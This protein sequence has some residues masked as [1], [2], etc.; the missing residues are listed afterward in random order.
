MTQIH[1]LPNF[2]RCAVVSPDRLHRG[3]GPW[4]V[5]CDTPERGSGLSGPPQAAIHYELQT[6]EED[7]VGYRH[8][9]KQALEGHMGAYGLILTAKAPHPEHG[10]AHIDAMVAL[11]EQQRALFPEGSASEGTRPEI[12]SQP[13]AFAA[14]LEK[15][16]AAAVYLKEKVEEMKIEQRML[17]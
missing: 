1:Q 4:H 9:V 7:P 8:M 2:A 14:A 16:S 10:P 15:T 17:I 13:E 5:S 3:R 11:A 12:W 6:I